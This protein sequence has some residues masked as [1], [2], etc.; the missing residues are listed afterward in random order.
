M[1]Y[2]QFS[3]IKI[4]PQ[5]EI[6]PDIRRYFNSKSF[7]CKRGIGRK[8]IETNVDGKYLCGLISWKQISDQ[9]FPG[10]PIFERA[11]NIYIR[12]ASSEIKS[13]YYDIMVTFTGIN[14]R[15]H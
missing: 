4:P 6:H 7:I 14:L 3:K 2:T 5:Q 15:S 12:K 9:I 10:D 11:D 8:F 1:G 13:P